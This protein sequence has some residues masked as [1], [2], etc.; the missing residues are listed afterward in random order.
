[1]ST[2]VAIGTLGPDGWVTS[3]V[4][5]FEY[6]IAHFFASEYSQTHLFKG[7]ISSLPWI[8]QDTQ[9]DMLRFC[10]AIESTLT[11]YLS[12]MFSNVVVEAAEVA[13]DKQFIGE[14]RLYVQVTDS[15]GTVLNLG[16][17]LRT[18]NGLIRE[19]VDIVNS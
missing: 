8:V 7:Y 2:Q 16:K 14:V 17:I 10:S 11:S 5:K 12:T 13:T 19:I 6:A 3:P 18:E 15:D 9:G 1:M 4:K